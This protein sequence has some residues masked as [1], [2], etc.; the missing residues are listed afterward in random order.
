M[1]YINKITI[2]LVAALA[3]VGCLPSVEDNTGFTPQTPEIS[4]S[5]DMMDVESDRY[6]YETQ[7]EDCWLLTHY[8]AYQNVRMNT[9]LPEMQQKLKKEV[10]VSLQVIS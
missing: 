7:V 1:K 4:F 2:M 3:F 8:E 10:T 5:E 9:D 6:S